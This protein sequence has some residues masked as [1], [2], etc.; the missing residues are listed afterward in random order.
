[1]LGYGNFRFDFIGKGSP[2]GV[3]D[4]LGGIVTETIHIEILEP[5]EGGIGEGIDTSGLK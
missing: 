4:V 1:M 5:P 2:E 3:G